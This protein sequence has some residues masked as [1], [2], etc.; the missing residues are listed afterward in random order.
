VLCNGCNVTV[1]QLSKARTRQ[2]PDVAV[3]FSG[4]S[5][6]NSSLNGGLQNRGYG[7]AIINDEQLLGTFRTSGY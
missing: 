2:V 7:F 1:V 5:C 4:Y 3:Q 6:K